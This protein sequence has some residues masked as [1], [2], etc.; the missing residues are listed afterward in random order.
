MAELYANSANDSRHPP[1]RKT[2]LN[3]QA[4]TSWPR[5]PP[6]DVPLLLAEQRVHPPASAMQCM[7]ESPSW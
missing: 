7:L 3:R 6:D 4:L 2:G 1:F 5:K